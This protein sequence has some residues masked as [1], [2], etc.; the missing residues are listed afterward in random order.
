MAGSEFGNLSS[1]DG[2][3]MTKRF[4]VILVLLLLALFWSEVTE[5]SEGPQ[6]SLI[7]VEVAVV[8]EVLDRT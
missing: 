1:S 5:G 3:E 2:V 4:D 6:S 7:L 8:E